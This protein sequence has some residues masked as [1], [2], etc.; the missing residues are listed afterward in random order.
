MFPNVPPLNALAG[1]FE[2]RPLE[3]PEGRTSVVDP[4]EAWSL[5]FLLDALMGRWNGPDFLYEWPLYFD[6]PNRRGPS[7]FAQHLAFA[8]VVPVESSPL[9]GVALAELIGT[10]DVTGLLGHLEGHPVLL[11]KTVGV[12][13]LGYAVRGAGQAV[14]IR[15]RTGLLRIMGI[16]DERFEAD[17]PDNE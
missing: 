11:L 16:R 8:P 9:A 14:Q 4:V 6:P 15:L 1:E 12:V 5:P 7:P 2:L 3:L 13:I 17:D 10:G